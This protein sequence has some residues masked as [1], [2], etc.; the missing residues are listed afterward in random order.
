MTPTPRGRVC[1]FGTYERDYPRNRTLA[2]GLKRAGWQVLECH[3]PLWEK[4]RDKTGRYLGPFSLVLRAV[5]LKLACLK[6][7][8]KYVFTV[9]RY[10]VMLVGYIGHFDMPLA[11]LLT[12]FPR[13]PLVFS[14]LIS[15]YDTL[16]DDRRSIADG[17]LMSRFLRWLDRQTCAKADL[18]L[19][20]TEAHIDYFVEEF[21][22][23]RKRFA[24][25]FVGAVEP[26]APEEDRAAVD[27][28]AIDAPA[29]DPSSEDT[30][31]RV[32]FVG[33]FIPLHG[34]PFMLEAANRL[35]DVPDIEFHF[36]GSGQLTDEIHETARRMNLENVRFADW[37]PYEQ[38][39]RFLQGWG[40]C[41]GI[42]GT[43]DKAV[44]VIPGKV[45]VALSA[46]KAV[47]TADSP[48]IR[49]LLT[50]GE[51]AILCRR[52]DP[53]ALAG[54]IRRLH[55]D[56]ELLRRIAEGG[57]RVF[58]DHASTEQIGRSASAVLEKLA[59]GGVNTFR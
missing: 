5:E 13:R 23:P 40:V 15:L 29:V 49:E 31:F 50:D 57:S 38:L 41:L 32:L 27:S 54:A 34:L 8:F 28:P 21:N 19:L 53:E 4:E 9:G 26:D 39:H 52:G 36:V 59:D 17:T 35:Q 18:V 24:R 11:W 55:G 14:P 10:D 46:G 12:R 3:V 43:S 47:I 7:L 37:I 58:R 48:A 56:R 42:F 1:F 30:P 20:D 6:L 51:S 22:L 45:F 44:R 25:V 16:V 33:K 2:E